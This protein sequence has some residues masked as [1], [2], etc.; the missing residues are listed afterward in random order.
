MRFFLALRAPFLQKVFEFFLR[1]LFLV[2]HL[3]R[4]FEILILDGLFFFAFDFL[5]LG[6]ERL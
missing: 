1:L 4:A 5:D 6:F 3:R 2:A